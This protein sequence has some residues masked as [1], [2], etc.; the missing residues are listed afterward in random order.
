[1]KYAGSA[2]IIITIAGVEYPVE[3]FSLE[4][5][6]VLI[7]IDIMDYLVKPISF[8]LFLNGCNTLKNI[9]LSRP[10]RQV[11]KSTDERFFSLC[12]KLVEKVFYNDL[13]YAEA[14]L[15]LYAR[16]NNI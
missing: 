3:A 9:Y 6:Y 16:R 1:M 10:P 4:M 11:S 13:R 14:M 15:D 12:N 5:L 7:K 2:S 8:E